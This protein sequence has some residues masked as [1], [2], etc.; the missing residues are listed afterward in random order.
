MELGF[1]NDLQSADI[2]K[3]SAVVSYK[4][5]VEHQSDRRNPGVSR[6]YR[7]TVFVS[8]AF[9]LRPDLTSLSSA[10]TIP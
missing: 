8:V 6:I 10:K 1:G 2:F 4:R 3:M 9:N 5:N 7:I